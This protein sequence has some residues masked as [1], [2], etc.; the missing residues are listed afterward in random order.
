MKSSY[1]VIR[2]HVITGFIFLMPVLISIA[3]IGKF[4]NKLLVLGNKVSKIIRV[5]TLLGNAGDAVIAVILLILLCIIAGFLVKLSVFKRM[6][7]WLDEKLAG[8]IPGYNDLRK[9]TE[10]KI[11]VA[12][13]AVEEIFDTC[14]IQTQDHWKPAYLIDV[15]DSGEATVFIPT[16]PTYK[17]GQVAIVP[18][19]SYKKLNIDSKTLNGYLTKMGRGISIA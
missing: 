19:N 3:V 10:N 1:K 6:S 16:A 15:A 5:D 9:E 14:L 7:D 4:W 8:F 2:N 13:K 12:P 11:G 17:T 18:A